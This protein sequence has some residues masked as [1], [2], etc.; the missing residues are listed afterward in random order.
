[1]DTSEAIN[2]LRQI[3]PDLQREYAVQAL[4]LF[5]S[6][7]NGTFTSDSDM[8]VVVEAPVLDLLSLVGIKLKLEAFFGMPVDVVRK[9]EYMPPRFRNRIE[10]EVIYV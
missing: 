5:G 9:T 4:G 10:K 6:F 8:D 3:K 2:K 7:A 1:M